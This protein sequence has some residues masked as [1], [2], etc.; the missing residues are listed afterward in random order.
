[1]NVKEYKW[2]TETLQNLKRYSDGCGFQ[3]LSND[4]KRTIVHF[5]YEYAESKLPEDEKRNLGFGASEKIPL[6]KH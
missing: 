4:L 1:M 3:G 2:I 5:E 6:Q